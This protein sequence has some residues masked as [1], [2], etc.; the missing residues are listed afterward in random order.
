M[1]PSVPVEVAL[2]A[3]MTDPSMCQ[4][5][6]EGRDRDVLDNLRCPPLDSDM[7]MGEPCDGSD[8]SRQS[9]DR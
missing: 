7:K 1:L 9:T 3:E 2:R 5:P 8:L 4:N 6:I